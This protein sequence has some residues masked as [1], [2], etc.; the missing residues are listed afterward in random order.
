MLKIEVDIQKTFFTYQATFDETKPFDASKFKIRNNPMIEIPVLMIYPQKV[1]GKD[2]L[3]IN[4]NISK[5]IIK[6]VA[7]D[8]V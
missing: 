3:P 7:A 2:G 6:G 8:W 5:E 4:K 1:V